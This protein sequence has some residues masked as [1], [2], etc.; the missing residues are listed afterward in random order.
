MTRIQHSEMFLYASSRASAISFLLVRLSALLFS[1][2]TSANRMMITVA[3]DRREGRESGK[4][5]IGDGKE[6][7]RDSEREMERD[8]GR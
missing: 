4:E 7:E 3:D 6:M 2:A 1:P 8:E 5:R